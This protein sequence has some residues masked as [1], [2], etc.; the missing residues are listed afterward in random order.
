MLVDSYRFLPR[1][2]LP[3]YQNAQPLDDQTDPVW[4]PF[5]KR[6]AEST[7]A[8]VSSA[9]L[10]VEGSQPPFDM[11]GE[12]RDPMWGD[13]SHRVIPHGVDRPLAMSHLHVNNAD[14]LADRNVALPMDVLDALVADGL[15]GR[16]ATDH[17][18]VM[19]YQQA[20]L[21]AWRTAT[22]PAIADLLR[23]Q[24]TDGVVLAPV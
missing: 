17:V 22:A 6:L 20:G 23:S 14:V 24:G 1:S 7:I 4:A 12:R 8:L 16:A 21:E 15:V 11:D 18:S 19:G 10:S 13:P 9:G 5:E 2:F 3:M